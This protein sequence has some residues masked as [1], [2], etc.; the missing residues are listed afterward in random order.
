VKTDIKGE[1]VL[2]NLV[3]GTY[4][5]TESVDERYEPQQ[6]KTVKMEADK[7]AMVTF[8]NILKKGGLKIIKISEDNVVADIEFTVTGKNFKQTVKTN[9]KG[10]FVFEN[11]VPGTYTVTESVDKRYEPQQPKTVKVEADK[12]ATVTF[13]NVLKKGDLK[14][15]KTS[16]DNI[17]ADIEFT[18]IGKNFKQ[19]VKTDSKG[20]I[21]LANLIPGTYTVTESV[22][23]R[24][25]DQQP[26]TVKVEADK[27]A[28]VTFKNVL[29]KGDL[30]IIKNSEDN[31]V[32]DIEFTV[33]GKNFKQTVKTDSK[34]EIVL[35]NLVPG[36]YTVTESVDKRY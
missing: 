13:K 30:K 11:L 10:E 3:P 1:I 16:E 33:T 31:I 17:V 20:E 25:E 34:G 19:T 24:Y 27:T 32:A 8:K 14:I 22:D 35:E 6:P 2:E 36:T 26:K 28:T 5:V 23:E 4:T 15:I 7:T 9:S 29:K 12:T 18:V 21:V